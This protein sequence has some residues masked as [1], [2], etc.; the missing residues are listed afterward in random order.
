MSVIYVIYI[1]EANNC[2]RGLKRSFSKRNDVSYADLSAYRVES[3]IPT[4]ALPSVAP[5]AAS[6]TRVKTAIVAVPIDSERT[7]T[8]SGSAGSKPQKH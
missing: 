6:V 8:R 4:M 1:E 5:H 7:G 3:L 2:L